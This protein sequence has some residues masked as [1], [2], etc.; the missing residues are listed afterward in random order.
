MNNAIFLNDEPDV[1]SAKV[2][3]M[4]TEPNHIRVEDPGN[5][6]IN[7]VLNILMLLT[8]SRKELKELKEH[9]KEASWEMLN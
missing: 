3:S 6:E 7:T 1:I 9:Y 8:L 5:V 4:Y 2:M